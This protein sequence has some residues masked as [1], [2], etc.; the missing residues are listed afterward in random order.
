MEEVSASGAILGV[1]Q[2]TSAR[3]VRRYKHPENLGTPLTE[4][5]LP[6]SLSNTSC[7]I[8]IPQSKR[9]IFSGLTKALVSE[10]LQLDS[11]DETQT[12]GE[13]GTVKS[14]VCAA[15]EKATLTPGTE[16][17]TMYQKLEHVTLTKP[18][19]KNMRSGNIHN[20]IKN[21]VH[22]CAFY[23]QLIREVVGPHILAEFLADEEKSRENNQ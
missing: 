19:K 12:L 8:T 5:D 22:F 18:M 15:L 4:R 14:E 11:V 1:K 13:A 16:W 3:L 6:R 21:C 7:K 9:H 17:K 2:S 20:A 10:L 23:E